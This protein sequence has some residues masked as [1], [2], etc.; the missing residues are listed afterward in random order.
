MAP[1]ALDRLPGASLDWRAVDCF[2]LGCVMYFV[3]SGGAHPFGERP[4]QRVG[5]ILAGRADVSGV[6]PTARELVARLLSAEPAARPSVTECQSHPLFWQEGRA[7]QFLAE[8]REAL[9]DGS[10]A[11]IGSLSKALAEQGAVGRWDEV[12]LANAPP[13]GEPWRNDR[14]HK[15]KGK[16]AGPSVIY[17]RWEKKRAS[18]SAC[19]WVP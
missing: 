18:W 8:V 6:E 13:G 4:M 3:L 1:E 17:E 9:G 10:T 11:W 12:L 5:A 14:S 15:N 2:S 7:L 19:G 16:W